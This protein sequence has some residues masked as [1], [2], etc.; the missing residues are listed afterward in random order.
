MLLVLKTLHLY[1]LDLNKPS[2]DV[3]LSYEERAAIRRA[4]R[5]KRKREREGYATPK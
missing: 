4:E 3:E 2:F 5:E 1:P